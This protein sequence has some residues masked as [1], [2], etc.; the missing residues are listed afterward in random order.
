M[1]SYNKSKD[2]SE[3]WEN[4]T[5]I[6]VRDKNIKQYDEHAPNFGIQGNDKQYKVQSA[7]VPSPR[8]IF[9]AINKPEIA[10]DKSIDD[11]LLYIA[12]NTTAKYKRPFLFSK[13]KDS[14]SQVKKQTKARIVHDKNIMVRHDRSQN[15]KEKDVASEWTRQ[16]QNKSNKRSSYGQYTGL[17]KNLENVKK[18]IYRTLE[19]NEDLNSQ[20]YSRIRSED[21]TEKRR[22]KSSKR[23]RQDRKHDQNS[24]SKHSKRTERLI[25]T[26]GSLNYVGTQCYDNE[27]SS[28]HIEGR[29]NFDRPMSCE[30]KSDH[31]DSHNFGEHRDQ[32]YQDVK[33]WAGMTSS[34]DL[35]FNKYLTN[36]LNSIQ[37]D[38]YYTNNNQGIK[39][40]E[41]N[42]NILSEDLSSSGLDNMVNDEYSGFSSSSGTRTKDQIVA[43]FLTA[44][45]NRNVD[46]KAMKAEKGLFCKNERINARKQ[47]FHN[48]GKNLNR[49][50][51]EWSRSTNNDQENNPLKDN[52]Q[53]NK[54]SSNDSS[55]QSFFANVMHDSRFGLQQ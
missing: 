22:R 32:N 54:Q 36:S 18:P 28:N 23:R 25:E 5:L 15:S 17:I 52:M 30:L 39:K 19:V 41:Q 38:K 27:S 7:F 6:S 11:S 14:D 12:S 26:H 50:S 44:K 37:V 40:D 51:L 24:R 8:N 9:R 29:Y 48:L 21:R 55:K 45:A 2:T 31:E 16:S 47:Y 1:P 3:H 35:Q 13:E 46:Y 42:I 33:Y 49:Q 34:K 20:E 43:G 4:E 10:F 53:H